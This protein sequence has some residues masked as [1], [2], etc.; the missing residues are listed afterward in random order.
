MQQR[1][2]SIAN[3]LVLR[4]SCTNPLIYY[5]M[6]GI[7]SP[8]YTD[9]TDHTI[10]VL[11]ITTICHARDLWK[12]DHFVNSCVYYACHTHEFSGTNFLSGFQSARGVCATHLQMEHPEIWVWYLPPLC[13][14]TVVPFSETAPSYEWNKPLGFCAQITDITMIQS[15]MHNNPSTKKFGGKSKLCLDFS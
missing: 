9:F 7:Q 11:K 8:I 14:M 5:A 10:T 15:P 4:L 3:A 2:N 13:I 12:L 6:D 1:H